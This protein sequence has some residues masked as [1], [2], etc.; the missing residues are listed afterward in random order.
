MID[1]KVLNSFQKKNV[2]ITGGT[3]LIGRQ[4]VQMLCDAGAFV[5]VVSLDNINVD[6]R[7]E[8]LLGD[9]AD[10]NLCKEITK[11]MD[12]AFHVAGIK[13][14]I[15]VTKAKPASFFVGLLMMNTTL[16]KDQK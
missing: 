15:D 16:P 6:S 8:H 1:D 13:G 11:D 7:A 12:F 2:V 5:K 10:F 9:L 14:S 4:I 3:G